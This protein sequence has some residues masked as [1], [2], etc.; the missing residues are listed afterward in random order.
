MKKIIILLSWI[1]LI[2]VIS[3][4]TNSNNAIVPSSPTKEVNEVQS[5]KTGDNYETSTTTTEKIAG[6]EN[7]SSPATEA[8]NYSKIG[9]SLVSETIKDMFGGDNPS[10]FV[11]TLGEP[12]KKVKILD[13]ERWYFKQSLEIDVITQNDI[14]CITN[15]IYISS[16]SNIKTSQNIGINSLYSD[17]IKAYEGEVNPE[18][19]DNDMVVAGDKSLGI[20]FIFH[21]DKVDS[22]YIAIG[23]YS[24][25]GERLERS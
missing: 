8:R 21:N 9:I 2:L 7:N 11:S 4:C 1:A 19:T 20:I 25:D 13:Y 10:D 17:V 22:I 24:M 15:Y 14:P 12:E 18:E 5:M 23:S 6:R 3:A 16:S